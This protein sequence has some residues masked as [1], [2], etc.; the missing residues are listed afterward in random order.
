MFASFV[1]ALIYIGGELS[2]SRLGMP[3]AITGVFQGILLLSLL[4]ADTF[5]YFRMRK[6]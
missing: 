4:T 3:A 1:M 6:T 2:Q 5:I